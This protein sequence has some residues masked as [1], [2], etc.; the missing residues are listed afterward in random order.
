MTPADPSEYP[1][2]ASRTGRLVGR[3]SGARMNEASEAT[4]NGVQEDE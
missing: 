2:V 1:E 4:Y 3:R